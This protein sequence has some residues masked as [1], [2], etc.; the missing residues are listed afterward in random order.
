MASE[1]GIAWVDLDSPTAARESRH[2][3]PGMWAPRCGQHGRRSAV[4]AS[5]SPHTTPPPCVLLLDTMSLRAYTR[6]N[7]YSLLAHLQ[8][9]L[10]ARRAQPSSNADAVPGASQPPSSFVLSSSPTTLVTTPVRPVATTPTTLAVG[11]RAGTS[12]A[13]RSVGEA[14]GMAGSSPPP[15]HSPL[16]G[17]QPSPVS[18]SPASDSLHSTLRRLQR[19]LNAKDLQVRVGSTV[20]RGYVGPNIVCNVAMALSDGGVPK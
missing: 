3:S 10:T 6:S 2:H 11:A 13:G 8:S 16:R 17:G 19:D 12:A 5:F 9:P 18:G 15:T 20:G 4:A 14:V 7:S 1:S